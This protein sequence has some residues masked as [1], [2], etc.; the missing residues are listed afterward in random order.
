[1]RVFVRLGLLLSLA[2]IV[3]MIAKQSVYENVST[4]R[5]EVFLN[6]RRAALA[7]AAWGG[8]RVD[9]IAVADWP[10]DDS[11]VAKA[12]RV[13]IGDRLR[14]GGEMF[15]GDLADIVLCRPS[16]AQPP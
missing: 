11:V 4:V 8:M 13:W 5:Q 3:F 6:E 2:I 12:A 14:N 9:W 7:T 16:C 10:T 15:N 1:M